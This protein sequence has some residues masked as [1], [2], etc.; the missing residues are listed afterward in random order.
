LT[1]K[2]SHKI[3]FVLE[4]DYSNELTKEKESRI[5]DWLLQFS[6]LYC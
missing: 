2:E 1:E 3:N 4:P 5:K 6:V